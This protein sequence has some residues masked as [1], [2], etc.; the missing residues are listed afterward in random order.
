MPS[1]YASNDNTLFFARANT[2]LAYILK[3]TSED[4]YHSGSTVAQTDKHQ[5]ALNLDEDLLVWKSQL[6]PEFDFDNAS[7]TEPETVTKRKVVLKLRKLRWPYCSST[8]HAMT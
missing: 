6:L 7:L 1:M 2:E 5:A 8:T 3:R 4:I